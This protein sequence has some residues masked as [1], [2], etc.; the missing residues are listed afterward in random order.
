METVRLTVGQA[1][2]KFLDN[3]FVEFDGN[4]EKFVGG[5]IGIFGHA[6]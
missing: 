4:I 6:W 3:Q 1:I 2:V 5:V